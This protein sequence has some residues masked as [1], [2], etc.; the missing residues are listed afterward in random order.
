M[1]SYT[2]VKCFYDVPCRRIGCDKSG[3]AFTTP[4]TNSYL[5]NA[6]SE[7]MNATAAVDSAY[8]Y[9]YDFDDIGNRKTSS[10]R[11]T[12]MS[13]SANQLNQ[14]TS[15]DTTTVSPATCH[16]PTMPTAMRRS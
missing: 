6:R 8:R 1:K 4:D 10:E 9:T 5:Y 13:Y 15:I 12:E 2:N 14:Y 7:L 11:G 16:L 3:S